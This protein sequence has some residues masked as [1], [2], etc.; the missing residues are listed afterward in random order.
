MNFN[1][2]I[3]SSWECDNVPNLTTTIKI[4][5]DFPENIFDII[6]DE[7]CISLKQL[8]GSSECTI[9]IELTESKSLKSLPNESR[10]LSNLSNNNVT[11]IDNPIKNDENYNSSSVSINEG[12]PC[13]KLNEIKS[14]YL[15]KIVILSEAKYIE[16]YSTPYSEYIST[17]HGNLLREF[18]DSRIYEFTISFDDLKRS[19]IIKP[20]NLFC[21]DFLWIYGIFIKVKQGCNQTFQ[22]FKP[23]EAIL[24]ENNVILSE[25]AQKF[26]KLVDVYKSYQNANT[27]QFFNPLTTPSVFSN[28]FRTNDSWDNEK[29]KKL[30]SS[31][32]SLLNSLFKEN[33]YKEDLSLNDGEIGKLFNKIQNLVIDKADSKSQNAKLL[34]G[35]SK[36][37]IENKKSLSKQ[38]QNQIYTNLSLNSDEIV[39]ST[40]IS[41]DVLLIINSLIDNKLQQFEEKIIT[42]LEAKIE[43]TQKI[44]ID[45]LNKIENKLF[46]Y[47]N[48]IKSNYN[49]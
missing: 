3:K 31:K 40:P 37:N 28:T 1:I 30:H 27:N 35:N 15:E 38:E 46:I 17:V 49:K 13:Q 10:I 8:S 12:L 36:S 25:E 9:A 16:L 45:K 34:N 19:I 14:N 48:S 26:K 21:S 23:L 32:I 2:D 47:T 20:K 29:I 22:G 33:S 24:K 4:V 39:Q 42:R 43:E 44:I 7:Q 6:T 18:E 11:P 41:E 5:E